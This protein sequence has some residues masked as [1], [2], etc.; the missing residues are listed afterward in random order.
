MLVKQLIRSTIHEFDGNT[1]H[2]PWKIHHQD[3]L[4]YDLHAQNLSQEG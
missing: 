3:I 4:V 1:C 2:T